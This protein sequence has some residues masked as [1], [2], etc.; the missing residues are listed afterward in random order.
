M[1]ELHRESAGTQIIIRPFRQDLVNRVW[2]RLRQRRAEELRRLLSDPDSIDLD[3]FNREV[4]VLE[5]G[6]SINGKDTNHRFS[7]SGVLLPEHV[8]DLEDSLNSASI[9]FHGNSIWGSASRVYGPMLKKSPDE[10]TEYIRY[11]LRILNGQ[12]P[13]L[14]KATEI[15]KVPGFGD[16][17]ATGLVMIYHPAEFAL[18]NSP[19]KT[20][21]DGIGFDSTTLESFEK[22]AR[23]LRSLLGAEDFIDLDAFL[24]HLGRNHGDEDEVNYWWVNQ[25]ATYQTESAGGYIWAPRTGR[26]GKTVYTHH[27]NVTLV[28]PGDIILH[29]VNGSIRAVSEAETHG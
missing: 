3:I 11:A 23:K 28:K 24:Y 15:S 22:S 10:K 12:L 2:I 20:A 21:F 7:S 19:T 6:S 9:E 1:N 13:P 27:H 14:E 25:G 26:D 8:R 18:Y 29:Y 16:N 5:S 17:V 4:W